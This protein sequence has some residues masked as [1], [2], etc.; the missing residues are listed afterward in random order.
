MRRELPLQ[1]L[2]VA[3][4]LTGGIVTR[5]HA[6]ETTGG[7][8]GPYWAPLPA[9]KMCSDYPGTDNQKAYCDSYFDPPNL[10]CGRPGDASCGVDGEN[11]PMIRCDYG[12]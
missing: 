10:N 3:I 1:F 9:G 7:C 8:A 12:N 6:R 11:G 4:I 5:V 2:S